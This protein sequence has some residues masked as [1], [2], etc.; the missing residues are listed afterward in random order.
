M[1]IERLVSMANQI[2]DFYQ[3]YPDQDQAQLEIAQHLNKFWAKSM[4][5]EMRAHISSDAGEG[6]NPIVLSALKAHL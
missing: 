3:A 2:G 5:D 4:R 1:Q 6:L